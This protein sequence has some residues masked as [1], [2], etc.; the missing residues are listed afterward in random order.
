LVLGLFAVGLLT[1]VALY[2][3]NSSAFSTYVDEDG[4]V[5]WIT[6]AALVSC[7]AIN[8]LRFFRLRKQ[9]TKLF[10]GVLLA[11]SLA[12]L[13]AVGE[14]L[15]WGQRIFKFESGDFFNTDNTQKEVNLHNLHFGP[16]K[17]NKLIFSLLLS[18]LVCV[19][20]IAMPV[21]YRLLKI[22][23]QWVDDLAIPVPKNYQLIAFAT[24]IIAIGFI[25]DI[26]KWELLEMSGILLLLVILLDPL[27]KE[28]YLKPQK[29][30]EGKVGE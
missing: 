22:V 12:L 11:A 7:A 29:T 25:H 13:F 28:I 17:L 27:N 15:S 2:F 14:E 9:K 19:Y 8:M 4:V 24:L 16:V 30:V 21:L 23:K 6:V 3:I 20:I 26:R 1:G 18:I 5:E 10:L